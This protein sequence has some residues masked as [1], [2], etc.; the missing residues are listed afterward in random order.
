MNLWLRCAPQRRAIAKS[1]RPLAAKHWRPEL[2]AVVAKRPA[3]GQD[4][5]EAVEL[6]D[7]RATRRPSGP[8]VRPVDR[9]DCRF[10]SS[11]TKA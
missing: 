11:R 8:D 10:L 6:A 5:P 7:E 9:R 2:S 1:P 4:R 3:G